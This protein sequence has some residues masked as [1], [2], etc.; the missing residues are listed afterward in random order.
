MPTFATPEPIAVAIVDV[1]PLD[2][3]KKSDVIAAENTQVTLANG[4]LVIKAPK[5]RRRYSV[6]N[7]TGSIAVAIDLPTRSRVRADAGLAELHTT[8]RLGDCRIRTGSGDVSLDEAGDVDLKSGR[9]DIAVAR[10]TGRVE[11]ATGS[12]GVRLTRVD[13]SATIKNASGDT[14]VGDIGGDLRVSVAR[15]AISVTRPQGAVTA[16]SAHGDVRVDQVQRGAVVAETGFGGVEVGLADGVAA[17]L[18]LSTGFGTVRNGL[19]S[20]DAPAPGEDAVEVRART[21]FGD[22]T[23]RRVVAAAAQTDS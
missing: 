2:P 22:I 11:I 19:D 12:G 6:R 17:W 5:E 21:G 8:G 20:A 23:I 15:G 16:K 7:G 14:S 1:R 3:S 13:G 9:G 4:E 18:D 10:A